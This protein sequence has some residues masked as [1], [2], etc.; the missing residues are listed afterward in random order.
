MVI[1]YIVLAAVPLVALLNV[2]LLI[3]GDDKITPRPKVPKLKHE[4]I[5]KLEDSSVEREVMDVDVVFV[6]AGPAGLSGALH[7][8]RLAK[9]HDEAIDKGEKKGEKLGELQIAVLEKCSEVGAMGISGMVL[10]PRSLKELMPDFEERGAP[11]EGK[12]Q[13][14]S[15]HMLLNDKLSLKAPLMPPPLQDHG[16]YVGSLSKFLRW[17]GEIAEE[18][19]IM[20][21]PGFAASRAL[22]GEG[23]VVEGVRTGDKGIGHDGEKRGNFEPGIDLKA[24]VTVLSE[25]TRG[26]VTRDVIDRL[27]LQEGKNPQVY[28]IGVKEVIEV[29]EG[30]MPVGEV[31]LTAGWP[32]DQATY[33]GSF[34]YSM[35]DNL[36]SLGLVIGL[37]YADPNLDPQA[38]LQRMKTH[39]V[40]QKYLKGGKVVQYGAKTIP[41]GGWFSRPR[42]YSDGLL[43]IGD[44]GGFVNAERLKGVHLA[45][46]TGLLAAQTVFE[47]LVEKDYSAKKLSTF[48]KRFE[49]SS[50]GKEMWKARNF[51]ASFSDGLLL[52]VPKQGLNM[53]TGGGS[54]HPHPTRP[55]WESYK[56]LDQVGGKRDVKKGIPYDGKLFLDK[57]SDVYLA[58]SKGGEDQPPHL[59]VADRNLC[60]E[61]CAEEFGNPCT[62]ACPANVYEMVDDDANPGKQKLHL[63]PTNCVHCKTC[64]LIDPYRNIRWVVPEGGDGPNYSQM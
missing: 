20:V 1:V 41:E 53:I 37:D 42:P 36:V 47:A 22:Y 40:F 46:K 9:E 54:K 59:Q 55:D 49:E 28:G 6:G 52:A 50:A 48:E 7:L 61:R 16:L 19:G 13:K 17:M 27:G 14:E 64:D 31:V 3:V 63:N 43:L 10:D 25:G 38:E 35:K 44:S 21:F 29:P 18:E 32:L 23:D 24:K 8:A 33:G 12:V 56:T 2:A 62:R 57:L 4:P 34:M 30:Q 58:G 26:S 39:P 5:E 15:M 60:W 11:F 51:H 45:I